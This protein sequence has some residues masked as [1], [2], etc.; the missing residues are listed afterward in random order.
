[1]PKGP[2]RNLLCLRIGCDSRRAAHR[3]R[4]CRCGPP[5]NG[6]WLNCLPLQ[7]SGAAVSVRSMCAGLSTIDVCPEHRLP[8]AV[9]AE[10]RSSQ[11]Q[12]TIKDRCSRRALP[13][14]H[15]TPS[16]D[17]QAIGCGKGLRRLAAPL[18]GRAQ[19]RLAQPVSPFGQGLGEQDAQRTCLPEARVV[20]LMLRKLCND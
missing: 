19:L 10:R 9:C 16:R 17:R 6:R 20:R 11:E 2:F 5:R 12:V 4:L 15:S 13:G 1:M 18:G 14:C 7:P 3:E 8:V